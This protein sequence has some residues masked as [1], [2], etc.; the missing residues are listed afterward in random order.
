M[1][2]DEISAR[3]TLEGGKEVTKEL[4]GIG[5]EADKLDGTKIELPI[6]ADTKKADRDIAGLMSKVERLGG[7]AGTILL[8]SNATEIAGEIADLIIDID[9]L[10]ASDPTVD[11]KATQINALQGDLDQI[12]AKIREVNSVPIEVDTRR[13]TTGI[14]DIGKS[15][16]SS[17]SA[18]A[19]MVGNSAQDLGALGGIA[20]STGVA[21]GQMAEYM[22]DAAFEGETL[23]AVAGNFAKVAGPILAIGAAVGVFQGVLSSLKSD[24]ADAAQATKDLGSAFEKTHNWVLAATDVLNKQDWESYTNRVTNFGEAINETFVGKA[25]SKLPVFGSHFKQVTTDIV[26]GLAKVG[27]AQDDVAKTTEGNTIVNK[28]FEQSLLDG[29]K[30]GKLTEREYKDIEDAVHSYQIEVKDA[31]T[32]Q[33]KA[34]LTAATFAETVRSITNQNDPLAQH[35]DLWAQLE[36]AITAGDNGAAANLAN[37]LGSLLGMD[38]SQVTATALGDL[39]DKEKDATKAAEDLA[40]KQQD[41]SDALGNITT[42][43]KAMADQISEK[44]FQDA[45]DQFDALSQLDLSQV[46]QDT[47]ASFDDVKEAI[48]TAAGEVEGWG[49]MDLTPDSFKELKGMPDAFAKITDA[50]SGMRASIQTELTAAFDTGGVQAFSDKFDFFA[51]QVRQQFTDLFR[52]M[53]LP[54]DQVQ[55]QVQRILGDLSLLPNDKTIV[56]KLTGEQEAKNALDVFKTQIDAIEQANPRVDISA[57]IAEGDIAGAMTEL[58]ALRVSQGKDPI[59]L[60]SD[61]DTKGAAKATADARAMAQ[62]YLNQH[63]G[64]FTISVDDQATVNEAMAARNA[65]Q[66]MLNA[67]HAYL[68]IAILPSSLNDAGGTVGAAGGIVAE[69]RPEIV[70]G[71]YLVTAPTAVPAGTRVTSGARTAR[72]LRTRGTRGLKGYDQ[73]GVVAGGTTVINFNGVGAI[74]ARYDVMRAVERANRD[75]RRLLGTR[76]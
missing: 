72:I 6:E 33:E 69:K 64:Q 35:A 3:V 61:V 42:D 1:A 36:R 68:P 26:A 8:T 76:G 28:D 52:G 40:K 47:V 60:P 22:A 9:R 5:K 70:N 24:E 73:G 56:I 67:N 13:A 25:L 4:Q 37:A 46:R 34:N 74:G 54:E 20:G 16:G 63:P 57:K 43:W 66:R 62:G 18:L 45:L 7:D 55:A 11:V 23:T 75:K 50:V 51:G 41:V 53:G 31:K 15:A 49:K 44:S 27:L 19:N 29:L 48:K 39:A 12:E 30:T 14:D 38:P 65:V 10:D 71:R 59:V 58:N 17:K 2:K 21:I 32:E